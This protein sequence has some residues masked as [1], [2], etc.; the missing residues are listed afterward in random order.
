MEWLVI[1]LLTIWM[2]YHSVTDKNKLKELILDNV[3]NYKSFM[4]KVR[5]IEIEKR[6]VWYEDFTYLCNT[7]DM[8]V[9]ELKMGD[10]KARENHSC[11]KGGI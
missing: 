9:V 4:D 2:T 10:I 6:F 8:F 11:T 3:E 7:C 1:V 5:I